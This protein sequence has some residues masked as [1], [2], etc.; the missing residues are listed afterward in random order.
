MGRPR[1]LSGSRLS[2]VAWVAMPEGEQEVG[3]V[4]TARQSQTLRRER[5][6]SRL[7]RQMRVEEQTP[8]SMTW[9]AQFPSELGHQSR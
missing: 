6:Q 3:S 8:T 5:K 9:I 2:I 7:L 1:A 4:R